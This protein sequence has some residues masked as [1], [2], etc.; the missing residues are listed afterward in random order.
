MTDSANAEYSPKKL[1]SLFVRLSLLQM[2]CGCSDPWISS[3]GVY[4]W[5]TRRSRGDRA[6]LLRATWRSLLLET[7][8]RWRRRR[9][10]CQPC[11]RR[12]AITRTCISCVSDSLP[13]KLMQ[14][15]GSGDGVKTQARQQPTRR[16]PPVC[17]G[18]GF[19]TREHK[20]NGPEG[21]VRC[22]VQW[23]SVELYDGRP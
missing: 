14:S 10:F 8:Q 20:G 1:L 12:P 18:R 21:C 16:Y 9:R 2:F 7:C 15:W 17:R 13:A 11:Q 3:A 5:S 6:R 4:S 22:G 19:L 23:G